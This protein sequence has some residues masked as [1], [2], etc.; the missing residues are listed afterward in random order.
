M[1]INARLQIIVDELKGGEDDALKVERGQYAAGT[2]LRKTAQQA[3]AAL[4]ELRNA[5]LELRG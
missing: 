5:V 3:I 2:R 4:K 1:S